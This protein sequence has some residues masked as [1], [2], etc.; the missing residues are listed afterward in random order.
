MVTRSMDVVAVEWIAMSEKE[1][2]LLEET[3]RLSEDVDYKVAIGT[4][5]EFQAARVALAEAEARLAAHQEI[6][7]KVDEEYESLI[8]LVY[9]EIEDELAS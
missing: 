4:E 7:K 3:L 9:G 8:N 6:F 2:L 5:E 1:G